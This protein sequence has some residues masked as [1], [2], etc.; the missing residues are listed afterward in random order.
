ML[1][2]GTG[3]VGWYTLL[4]EGAGYVGGYMLLLLEVVGWIGEYSVDDEETAEVELLG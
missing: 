1:P 2:E 3:Y 4:D